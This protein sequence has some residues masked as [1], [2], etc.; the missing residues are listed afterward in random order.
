MKHFLV[1][2][3]FSCLALLGMAQKPLD[4]AKISLSNFQKSK[5]A[6]DLTEANTQIDAFLKTPE[7]LKS[8]EAFFL[9]GIL[10]KNIYDFGTQKNEKLITDAYQ[11]FKTVLTQFSSFEEKEKTVEFTKYLGFDLY[12]VGIEKFNKKDY[13]GAYQTYEL[14]QD[15][16][17]ELAKFDQ[18]LSYVNQTNNQKVELKSSDIN[19]NFIIFAS[20]SG[21]DTKAIGIL[22]KE[23]ETFPTANKYLQLL[24]FYVKVPGYEAKFPKLID[25]AL[26][27][28]PKDAD[29]L[30]YKINHLM[31][32]NQNTEAVSYLKKAIE[33]QPSKIEF[34]NILANI[35]EKDGRLDEA[36]KTYESAIK[37]QPNNY[38]ANFN[39][40]ALVYNNSIKH[41]NAYNKEAR[42]DDQ[43]KYTE[44]FAKALE[45]FNKVKTISPKDSDK[46]NGI[47]N[48]IQEIK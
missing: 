36:I 22:E 14:L 31:D 30:I 2:L 13:Q 44:G 40:A 27:K 37:A 16:Q 26:D 3:I 7:G 39:Y 33:V 10:K 41:Y 24:Q 42:P 32:K 45:L 19:N 4:K 20:N 48:K 5:S 23:I 34:Y 21:N 38:E 18:T 35:H 8:A 29:L 43:K 11:N 6:A 1:V 9:S 47:I 28:F 15:L 17:N 25:Q 46:L 12:N